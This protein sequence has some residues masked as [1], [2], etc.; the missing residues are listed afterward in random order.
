MRNLRSKYWTFRRRKLQPSHFPRIVMPLAQHQQKLENKVL[1][2]KKGRNEAPSVQ[3][4]SNSG[5]D[6]ASRWRTVLVL[7]H[8]VVL[9]NAKEVAIP[10]EHSIFRQF[11]RLQNF[12]DQSGLETSQICI[13]YSHV[14][15]SLKQCLNSE[16]LMVSFLVLRQKGVRGVKKVSF[17]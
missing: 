2:K 11:S 3:K 10:L 1:L 15:V 4:Y 13:E 7:Q 9:H 12:M 14:R 5:D 17:Q 16:V 8:S 6:N